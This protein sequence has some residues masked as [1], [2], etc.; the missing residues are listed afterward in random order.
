MTHF[1]LTLH[2][3]QKK[4][5]VRDADTVE[6]DRKA[7]QDREVINHQ[8][9]ASQHELKRPVSSVSSRKGQTYRTLA[10]DWCLMDRSTDYN[11]Y[12]TWLPKSMRRSNPWPVTGPEK[13]AP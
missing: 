6:A 8:P 4:P 2:K 13:P 3:K 7:E 10:R 5:W 12:H 9:D 11:P 1:L